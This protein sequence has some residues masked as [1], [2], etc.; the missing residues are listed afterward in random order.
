M[1]FLRN[2]KMMRGSGPFKAWVEGCYGGV[3]CPT[4]ESFVHRLPEQSL[5]LV[6]NFP[7]VTNIIGCMTSRGIVVVE[8]MHRCTAIT[9]VAKEGR[10]IAGEMHILLADNDYALPIPD[11]LPRYTK[12]S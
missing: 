9:I 3:W 1:K 10:Q 12:V 7:P 6:R 8:G 2:G 4:F 5:R 11:K